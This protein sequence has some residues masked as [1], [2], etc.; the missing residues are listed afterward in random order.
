MVETKPEGFGANLPVPSGLRPAG[1][2]F[3]IR[4]A[5]CAYIALRRL[6]RGSPRRAAN[7]IDSIWPYHALSG[8]E[9]L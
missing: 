7:R 4:L 5:R 2:H 9:R 3:V 1:A 6:P 8:K